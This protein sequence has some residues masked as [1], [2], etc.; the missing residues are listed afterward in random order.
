M[1]LQAVCFQNYAWK[2]TFGALNEL[3]MDACSAFIAPSDSVIMVEKAKNS[4]QKLSVSTS[5]GEDTGVH[6]KPFSSYIKNIIVMS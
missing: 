3:W 5:R 2:Q 4:V 1:P 6:E